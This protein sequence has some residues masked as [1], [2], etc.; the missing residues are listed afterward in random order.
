MKTSLIIP[1][2]KRANLLNLG[3]WSI[4][5]Q[6][7]SYDLE[8]IVLNDGIQDETEQICKQ[9]SNRLDIKYFFTGQRNKIIEKPRCPVLPFNI[10]VKKAEGGIIILSSPEIFHLHNT[11][12]SVVEALIKNEKTMVSPEHIY[13]DN[14][15]QAKDYLDKIL[16]LELPEKVVSSLEQNSKRCRYLRKIPCFMGMYKKDFIDIGGYDED[17]I[18]IA[19]EDD[20]LIWRLRLK[21]LTF[22]FCD[23]SKIIHLYHD[24]HFSKQ[25]KNQN[26][27]YLYNL[28][29]FR[30]RKGIINRNVGRDWGRYDEKS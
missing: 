4:A 26:K 21:G 22:H 28:K 7:I 27:D 25:D 1:C 24:K 5:R 14:T 18:G 13:V 16:T 15:G 17:F 23:D 19:G 29:L 9:Y 3:L 8:V 30:K 20:D 12:N 10:G 2:F 6:R 11:V